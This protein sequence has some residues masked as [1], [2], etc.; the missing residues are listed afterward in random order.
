MIVPRLLLSAAALCVLTPATARSQTPLGDSTLARTVAPGVTLRRVVLANGPV[1]M[2]VL[3]VDLRRPELVVRAVRACDRGT[4]RERPSAIARRLR[5]DGVD[6]IAAI[7]AGFFD[8]EGGTGTSES[9]VVVDGEIAKGVELTESPF[10]KFDNVHSQF[11]FTERRRPIIDRLRLSGILRTSRG[12]RPLGAVNGSPVPNEV[13]L[14]T[15]WS[16]RAP[17]YP[18]AIRTSSVPLMRIG[19]ADSVGAGT[20]K[21]VVRYRVIAPARPD[22]VAD[23][24]GTRALLVATGTVADGIGRLRSGDVVTI[25]TRFVPD[26]GALRSV[27]GGWPRIVQ[28]G[29][30]ISAAADTIEGTFPRFAASRHPRSVVGFSRDSS[31]LYL[32]AVDGRQSSSVGMSLGELARAAIALGVNDAL[33]LDGGGSTAL[34]VGDSVVN[35]PSDATGERPVG[36]AL[37]ISRDTSAARSPRRNAP[38]KTI[39]PSCVLG[40]NR[41]PDRVT[42]PASRP[43]PPQ[44]GSVQA[45][46]AQTTPVQPAPSKP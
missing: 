3:E 43:G 8:L 44:T 39:A 5:A 38:A 2:Y 15:R 37:V 29:A 7:N 4:G 20:G 16:G 14:Y 42:P 32:I 34:V 36:D 25:E 41:D 13:A 6:V 1:T 23:T 12:T 24:T 19:S 21:T 27:V 35:H 45:P 22:T 28:G 46:P 10:D 17:R 40:G 11:G 9:N 30:D 31:T 18:T 33:N 26:R